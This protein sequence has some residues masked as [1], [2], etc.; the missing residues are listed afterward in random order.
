M[1]LFHEL[2][3][4]KSG[5]ASVY[6]SRLE[7]GR[8]LGVWFKVSDSGVVSKGSLFWAVPLH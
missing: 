7:G 6:S 8:H 3:T 1:K 4:D 5:K 2:D